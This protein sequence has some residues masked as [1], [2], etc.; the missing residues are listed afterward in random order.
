MRGLPGYDSWLERPYQEACAEQERREQAKH[1]AD[2]QLWIETL[3]AITEAKAWGWYIPGESFD[4]PYPSET[5]A[6]AEM[7]DGEHAMRIDERIAFEL[8]EQA[9]S[10]LDYA[11]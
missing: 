1:E 10:E 4:G 7:A 3:I 11:Y 8:L 2:L 9:Y 5:E 6:I